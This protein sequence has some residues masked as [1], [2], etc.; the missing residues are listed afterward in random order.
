MHVLRAVRKRIAARRLP[1]LRRRIC[2][3]ADPPGASPGKISTL[4]DKTA[5]SERREA[6]T[7]DK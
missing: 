2:P 1:E 6:L 7:G 5:A 4:D 3:A